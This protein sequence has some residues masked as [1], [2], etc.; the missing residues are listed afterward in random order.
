MQ[1]AQCAGD[2]WRH[3]EQR[4]G[5]KRAR[6]EGEEELDRHPAGGL[7]GPATAL[8]PDVVGEVAETGGERR[9]IPLGR[10]KGGDERAH[11]FS[12][13]CREI[14][15]RVRE[16][17]TEAMLVADTTQF[18]A[19]RALGAPGHG[20]DSERHGEAGVDGEHNQVDDLG[21]IGGERRE[22]PA[23]GA[24]GACD[25][26]P[27]GPDRDHWRGGGDDRQADSGGEGGKG[28]PPR[29]PGRQPSGESLGKRRPL[30]GGRAAG[31]RDERPPG[32]A[33]RQ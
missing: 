10:D 6:D 2:E 33:G 27:P 24:P 28:R 5:G 14:V 16:P 23:L 4:E 17:A 12:G 20:S 21:Q 25:G 19:E 7:L 1:L 22:P 13:A 8:T 31:R 29:D 18:R 26:Q 9:P 3:R 15:E 32:E 30:R 11:G